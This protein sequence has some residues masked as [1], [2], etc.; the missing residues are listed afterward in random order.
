M[1][2]LFSQAA[3][4]NQ[5]V[6]AFSNIEAGRCRQVT[7]FAVAEKNNTS[8]M[9]HLTVSAGWVGDVFAW[10][11]QHTLSPEVETFF[12]GEGKPGEFYLAAAAFSLGI[13]GLIRK[14]GWAFRQI[15]AA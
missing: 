12:V 1:P 10:Q 5:I 8:S 11:V 2:P 3:I 15:C 7:F 4:S 14:D 6:A 9:L 13:G